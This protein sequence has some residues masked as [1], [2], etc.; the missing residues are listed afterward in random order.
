MCIIAEDVCKC[1][2]AVTEELAHDEELVN[3]VNSEEATAC[4]MA[5]VGMCVEDEKS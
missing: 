4:V 5:G 1:P 2:T 3:C